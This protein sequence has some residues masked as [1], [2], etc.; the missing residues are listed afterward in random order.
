MLFIHR[1]TVGD[2]FGEGADLA[3]IPFLGAAGA[4]APTAAASARNAE[5]KPRGESTTLPV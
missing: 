1:R 5:I 2:A 3:G 4:D